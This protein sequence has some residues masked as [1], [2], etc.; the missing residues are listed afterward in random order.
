MNKATSRDFQNSLDTKVQK[1][2]KEL[3]QALIEENISQNMKNENFRS[4]IC[5]NSNDM[6]M[7][8]LKLTNE[9]KELEIRLREE[10][11]EKVP[12]DDTDNVFLDLL[13]KVLLKYGQLQEHLEKSDL[14]LTEKMNCFES[15]LEEKQKETQ[16]SVEVNTE[17]CRKDL[18][19]KMQNFRTIFCS[20]FQL[21]LSDYKIKDF[22]NFIM[23]VSDIFRLV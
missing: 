3:K 14:Q 21:Q 6:E 17:L 5:Q 22:K 8:K 23:N 10:M 9:R 4:M 20:T 1:L 18:Q 15:N 16:T 19:T 2:D 13:D 12:D 7:V 11:T